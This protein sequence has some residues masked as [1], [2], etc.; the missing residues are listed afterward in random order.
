ME[1]KAVFLSRMETSHSGETVVWVIVREKKQKA[2]CSKL[3]PRLLSRLHHSV[4]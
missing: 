3:R 2:S 1:F 4:L